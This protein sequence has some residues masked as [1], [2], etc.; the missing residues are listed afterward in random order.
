MIDHP[1][2]V[3]NVLSVP[4]IVVVRHQ[5]GVDIDIVIVTNVLIVLHDVDIEIVNV[6]KKGKIGRHHP[7]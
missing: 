5:V 2:V 3:L 4:I 1:A 7:R 6:L